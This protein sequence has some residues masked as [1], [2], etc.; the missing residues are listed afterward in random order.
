MHNNAIYFSLRAPIYAARF[1]HAIIILDSD[2]DTYLSLI[3]D[4]ARY[5]LIILQQAFAKEANGAYQ[6]TCDGCDH[7]KLN[8]WITHFLERQFIV[9][10]SIPNSKHITH[11]LKEG[12]LCD[13]RWDTK[14]SWKPFAHAPICQ[15]FKAWVMLARV[16]RTMKRSGT[17]GLLA[18]ISSYSEQ[19]RPMRQP[20]DQEIAALASIVDAA[21]IL[22]PKKTFCLAW[23]ATYVCMALKRG[24]SAHLVIGVQT[25]PFYAHAWADIEGKVIHDDPEIANVLSIILK[26]SS[27]QGL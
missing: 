16:H 23:S 22:Y 4:A 20:T 18:L 19:Y 7:E 13:Y 9:H 15:V 11:P 12:G 2:A 6:A 21:S 10:S 5:L 17:K 27:N 14:S 24:W 3:D 25:N 1:D 8:F 26:T